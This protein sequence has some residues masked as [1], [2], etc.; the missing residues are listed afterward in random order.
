MFEKAYQP[1]SVAHA[2]MVRTAHT[3][4]CNIFRLIRLV[5]VYQPESD[6]HACMDTHTNLCII[7]RLINLSQL[8]QFAS[9]PPPNTQKC[10]TRGRSKTDRGSAVHG[11][12]LTI[13]HGSTIERYG[14]AR[15][16][17]G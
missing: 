15:A 17:Y 16:R 9:A 2:S 1:E 3:D 12:D 5:E 7:N 11:E 4:L 14:A 6:A 8:L 13:A 10:A